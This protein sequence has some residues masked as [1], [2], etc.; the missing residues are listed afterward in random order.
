M[1]K[2]F[3]LFVVFF[4]FSFV[5]GQFISELPVS[6]ISGKH[7]FEQTDGIAFVIDSSDTDRFDTVKKEIHALISH[8]ELVGKPFLFLANK[9][10]LPQAESKESLIEILNLNA[11]KTSEWYIIECAA[12][13]NERAKLGFEWLANQL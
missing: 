8:K 10:D 3:N 1:F 11:I 2:K 4:L 6:N 13:K 5:N 12:T 9:Q 7:Y